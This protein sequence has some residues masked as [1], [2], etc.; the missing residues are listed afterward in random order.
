M[1]SL[2]L[3][4]TP[5]SVPEPQPQPQPELQP[6]TQD[7][8]EKKETDSLNRK[9][10]FALISIA[11]TL[12]IMGFVIGWYSTRFYNENYKHRLTQALS[13]LEVEKRQTTIALQK[14]MQTQNEFSN[15]FASLSLEF[16]NLK[17]TYQSNLL[18]KDAEIKLVKNNLPTNF[19]VN[20]ITNIIT[21][22]V[23]NKIPTVIE[24]FKMDLSKKIEN[25]EGYIN[26]ESES[27]DSDTDK[28]E[29]LQ[30]NKKV[31]E[32]VIS[33]VDKFKEK[34]NKEIKALIELKIKQLN[35]KGISYGTNKSTIKSQ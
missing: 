7:V 17:N 25:I 8:M 2:I 24:K 13:N 20:T 28:I 35:S 9:E 15:K 27:E 19:V 21:N 34:N 30:K 18:E 32:N 22:T 33:D 16:V 5:I 1:G 6:K 31:I 14:N 12:V 23:T 4:N 11:M 10:W 3:P 26:K 29:R